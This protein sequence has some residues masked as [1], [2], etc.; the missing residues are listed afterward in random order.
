[1]LKKITELGSLQATAT[2]NVARK[3]NSFLQYAATYPVTKVTYHA[4]DMILHTHSDASYLGETKGSSR[5]AGFHFLGKQHH[6]I[7]TISDTP[8][9]GGFLIRSSILDV[10]VSSAAEAELGGLFENMR[11]AKI[12]GNILLANPHHLC[13]QITNLQREYRTAQSNQNALKHLICDTIGC[14]TGS[15]KANSMYTGAK[16]G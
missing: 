7:G 4:S 5:F 14:V 9:N 2:E 15:I 10:V 6:R 12:L 16:A 13:K 1:M 3:V 11:D 8:I